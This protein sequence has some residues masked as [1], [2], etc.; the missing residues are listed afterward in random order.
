MDLDYKK[1]K[2]YRKISRKLARPNK[3]ATLSP[4]SVRISQAKSENP[5]EKF[6]SGLSTEMKLAMKIVLNGVSNNLEYA[7]TLEEN[8]VSLEVSEK[9]VNLL[10]SEQILAESDGK[11]IISIEKCMQDKLCQIL[12]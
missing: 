6:V 12:Y 9:A 10:K 2:K 4:I 8:N 11:I 7:K 1:Y 3:K 5:Y